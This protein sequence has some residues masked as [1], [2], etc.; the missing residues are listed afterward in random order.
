MKRKEKHNLNKINSFL[1]LFLCILS[2]NNS[3]CAFPLSFQIASSLTKELCALV[4][5]VNTFLGTILKTVITLIVAD[6]RGLALDV[7][8]QVC[9]ILD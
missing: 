2:V 6:K 1:Q 3:F 5:G 9:K 8:S 4:F 7:H